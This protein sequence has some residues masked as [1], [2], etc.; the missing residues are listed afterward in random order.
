M[1]SSKALSREL[2]RGKRYDTSKQL[3]QTADCGWHL[4]G[5]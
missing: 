2:Y 1:G 3:V 4:A 5:S